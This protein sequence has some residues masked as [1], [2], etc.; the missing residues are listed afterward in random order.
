LA[1][2]VARD[3]VGSGPVIVIEFLQRAAAG[4]EKVLLH[5]DVEPVLKGKGGF[6]VYRPTPQPAS[7]ST[8]ATMSDEITHAS[9]I[10]AS[11]KEQTACTTCST[12]PTLAT[13]R[14]TLVEH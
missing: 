9:E 12:T 10:D 11:T 14:W 5:C 6:V 8:S 3:C 2:T 1:L 7:P 4:D 13:V